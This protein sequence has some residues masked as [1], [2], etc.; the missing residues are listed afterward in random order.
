[1]MK[2]AF[3]LIL[4]AFFALPLMASAVYT[5]NQWH[6]NQLRSASDNNKMIDEPSAFRVRMTPTALEIDFK[7]EGPHWKEFQKQKFILNKGPW[8]LEESVELFFDP[9]RSCSKYIQI[10]A[11]VKGTMFD[12]RFEKSKAPWTATWTVTREDFKGGVIFRFVIPFD[13]TFPKPAEGE[14]WGF[15]ACRNVVV[16][17]RLVNST[18]AKVG[19]L[20]HNPS[21]F[22]ELRIGT[23]ESFRIANQRKN[24]EQLA[25]LEK[26]IR[27]AGLYSD[28]AGQIAALKKDCK[29]DKLIF[30]NDEFQM[31]RLMKEVK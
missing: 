4:C 22:A 17:K 2:S 23:K 31:I 21:K 9:G 3:L 19:H 29:E 16:G 7:I 18:Y 15:N 28:F 13:K 26:E 6:V 20:F 1:M 30:L 24:L 11:G 12:K 10:A 5:D 14:I 8:P 25:K 27:A